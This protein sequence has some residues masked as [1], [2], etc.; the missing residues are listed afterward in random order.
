MDV[1]D[2]QQKHPS[3]KVKTLKTKTIMK[4]NLIPFAA[5]VLLVFTQSCTI[6]SPYQPI[7]STVNSTSGDDDDDDSTSG[8]TT[9]GTTTGAGTTT[10]GTTTGGTTT[11]AGTTTGGTTTGGT[12]TGSTIGNTGG[13]SSTFGANKSHNAGQNCMSCHNPGGSGSSKGVWK[14][15][16]T[17][18]NEL[19]TATYPNTTINLYTGPNGTGTLKYVLNVD[20]KGNFY[21]S[22]TIDFTGGLYPAVIG[23]TT[24]NHMSSP[25][26]TG[27]CNSCHTGTSTARIWAK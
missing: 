21:T 3:T 12:T 24:T 15:A 16:G 7:D 10:G 14:L 22:G 19:K 17:V 23:A 26:T 25:V 18:Y 9:G 11:G 6:E 1:L 20:A 5:I 27:A 8:T 13:T 2:R 4:L